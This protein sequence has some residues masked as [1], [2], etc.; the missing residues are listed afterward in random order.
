MKIISSL[1]YIYFFILILHLKIHFFGCVLL[2]SFV[3]GLFSAWQP[4]P[5]FCIKQ[6]TIS[7]TAICRSILAVHSI[8]KWNLSSRIEV[9]TRIRGAHPT[10]RNF[11]LAAK[12][13]IFSPQCWDGS[14]A[15]TTSHSTIL[16]GSFS[17]RRERS[18]H[19]DEGGHSHPSVDKVTKLVELYLFYSML[20]HDMY[21]GNFDFEFTSSYFIFFL[22]ARQPSS[23]PGPPHSR[24][25]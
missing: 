4:F 22:V 8:L 18:L 17:W 14:G 1:A 11:F 2:V 5:S 16:V 19:C 12:S 15:H 23:R 25:F 7:A 10:V 13:Y 21:R 9:L 6:K 20:L 3:Q 24:G